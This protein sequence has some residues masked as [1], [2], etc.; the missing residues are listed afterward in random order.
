LFIGGEKDRTLYAKIAGR[1]GTYK[2]LPS[3]FAGVVESRHAVVGKN[4]LLM[5]GFD[6]K[7]IFAID[8]ES[9]VDFLSESESVLMWSEQR[10]AHSI[11][12]IAV[13]DGSPDT[14][15]LTLSDGSFRLV[16][17]TVRFVQDNLVLNT[18]TAEGICLEDL[19]G[20]IL[21]PI[22]RVAHNGHLI[23]ADRHNTSALLRFDRS[24]NFGPK[25]VDMVRRTMM[26][27]L[28]AH[29]LS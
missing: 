28:S 27:K 22:V 23:L 11:E 8:A 12:D 26:R 5:A 3:P 10:I 20:E 15:I 7:D 17:I 16:P 1:D 29:S 19:G 25:F 4:I 6:R 21:S 18:S 2:M 13:V 9:I 24:T 14:V